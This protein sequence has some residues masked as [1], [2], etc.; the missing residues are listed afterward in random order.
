MD[1]SGK[2]NNGTRPFLCNSI[3]LSNVYNS[4]HWETDFIKY[5]RDKETKIVL[6]TLLLSAN[7]SWSSEWR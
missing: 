5:I 6:Y 1:V 7:H 4:E 3:T 2:V